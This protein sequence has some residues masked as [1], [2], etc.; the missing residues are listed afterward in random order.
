LVRHGTQH[1]RSRSGVAVM[2]FLEIPPGRP[3]VHHLIMSSFHDGRPLRCASA[4]DVAGA[5]A[6]PRAEVA[7]VS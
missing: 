7:S 3:A 1:D 5:L 2:P 6:V 4:S